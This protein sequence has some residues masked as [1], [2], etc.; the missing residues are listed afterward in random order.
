MKVIFLKHVLNVAKVG[1]IKDV[2]PWYALNSLIPQGL[3]EKL[4]PQ[5]EKKY[6]DQAKKDDLNRIS[7]SSDKDSIIEKL[8]W[9]KLSFTLKWDAKKIFWSI[10]EKDILPMLNKLTGVTLTKKYIIL[11]GGHI[12][13]FGEHIA[14]VKMWKHHVARIII[15]ITPA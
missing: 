1:D 14:H 15:D 6:K 7:L 9:Q 8:E 3:A 4:T 2:K 13:T 11:P 5:L 12:K 10:T